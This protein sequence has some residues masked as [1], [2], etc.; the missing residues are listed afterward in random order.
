MKKTLLILTALASLTIA[1]QAQ[2]KPPTSYGWWTY[3]TF[4]LG[5]LIIEY[6]WSIY[7][8]DFWYEGVANRFGIG[9]STVFLPDFSSDT[10]WRDGRFAHYEQHPLGPARAF[11][12]K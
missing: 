8:G 12:V 5:G 4:G 6:W 9:Y 1:S 3:S 2:L 11:G 7:E 10:L